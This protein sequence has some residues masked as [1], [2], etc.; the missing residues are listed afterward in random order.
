MME[1]IAAL[2][3]QDFWIFIVA[4][5]AFVVGMGGVING[6]FPES[7]LIFP[8][9]TG[10]LI[11]TVIV[12]AFG[13]MFFGYPSPL[14]MFFA[15]AHLGWLSKLA[16][17]FESSILVVTLCCLL[18]SY[19]SIKLGNSLLEDLAE[20]GNFKRALWISALFLVIALVLAMVIDF[21]VVT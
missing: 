19:A 6:M 12:F 9:G 16:G 20:K 10:K 15:G 14:I 5:V 17:K 4:F 13:F 11:L 18:A 8:L 7:I 3:K 21:G 2:M 1:L